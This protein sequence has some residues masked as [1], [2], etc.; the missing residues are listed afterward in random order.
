MHVKRT[1]HTAKGQGD[2]ERNAR[3]QNIL[4][5][6]QQ[7]LV[8]LLPT[9]SD[10]RR[11]IFGVGTPE[12]TPSV[13]RDSSPAPGQRDGAGKKEELKVVAAEK[14]EQLKKASKSGRKRRN[15]WMFGLG[16][17]FGILVAGFF[18]SNNG[19]LERLVDMAGLQ[20]MNLDSIL[21]VLPTGLIRDIQDI[22]VSYVPIQE[23]QTLRQP[24]S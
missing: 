13:S 14:L 11:R 6:L 7:R 2:D 10:L 8:A 18:A 12:S 16:G 17:L 23:E 3:A 21:D 19:G 4:L 9:M 1:S 20:D 22:Q 24:G 15:A 5:Q